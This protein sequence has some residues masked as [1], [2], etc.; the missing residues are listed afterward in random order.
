MRV[1]P[2]LLIGA[3]M[4]SIVLTS[5]VH[6]FTITDLVIL[7]F[8]LLAMCGGIMALAGSK[9]GNWM[10]LCSSLG[11]LAL[12]CFFHYSRIRFMIDNGSME[13]PDG[14]GSPLAFLLGWITT[15]VIFFLPGLVWTAWNLYAIKHNG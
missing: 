8:A 3:L 14:Y 4:S 5:M 7:P 15:T 13:G 1:Y 11:P 2:Q 12:G 6:R 10:L 9:A